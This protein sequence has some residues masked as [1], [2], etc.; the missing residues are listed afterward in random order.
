MAK[1]WKIV[2]V[3]SFIL[4]GIDCIATGDYVS[5]LIGVLLLG[6]AFFSVGSLFEILKSIRDNLQSIAEMQSERARKEEKKTPVAAASAS[7]TEPYYQKFHSGKWTC[8][9]CNYENDNVNQYCKQCG[10]YK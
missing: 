5:G 6:M 8:K 3:L 4:G 1:F 2:A 9:D 7:S 10:K